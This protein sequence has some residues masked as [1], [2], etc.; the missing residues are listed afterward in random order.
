MG[1]YGRLGG[2]WH[3]VHPAAV[4]HAF[5]RATSRVLGGIWT[6]AVTGYLPTCGS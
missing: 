6:T 2:V 4:S 3:W 1:D 5:R